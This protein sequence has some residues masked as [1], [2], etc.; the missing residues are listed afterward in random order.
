MFSTKAANN[1]AKAV[2]INFIGTVETNQSFIGTR[3]MLKEKHHSLTFK[4][5]SVESLDVH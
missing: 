3:Q 1:L 5:I 2:R 4:E